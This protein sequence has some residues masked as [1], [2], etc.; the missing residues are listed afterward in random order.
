MVTEDDNMDYKTNQA[1]WKISITTNESSFT[2]KMQIYAHTD[3]RSLISLRI[4]VQR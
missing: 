2:L 4:I 1:Y 3:I